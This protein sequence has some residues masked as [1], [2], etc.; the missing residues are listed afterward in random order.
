[1]EKK[2]IYVILGLVAAAILVWFI[3]TKFVLKAQQQAA[4]V[5]TPSTPTPSPLPPAPT[6]PPFTVQVGSY[7]A[8]FAG[9][10]VTIATSPPELQ[11][12][13]SY[14]VAVN[15]PNGV[16]VLIPYPVNVAQAKLQQGLLTPGSTYVVQVVPS[17][18]GAELKQ[19]SSSYAAYGTQQITLTAGVLRDIMR[20]NKS[21][22]LQLYQAVSIN[23]TP[24]IQS[25]L[26]TAS[27]NP[28]LQN[29]L[30]VLSQPGNLVAPLAISYNAAITLGIVPPQIQSYITNPS[31]VVIDFGYA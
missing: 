25:L 5:P 27:N 8:N 22:F 26:A 13:D 11:I 21:L 28:Q 15:A 7:L 23:N 4:V 9:L 20:G 2:W 24:L 12:G 29:I 10:P 16:L 31:N 1:M 6:M 17:A 30:K 18:L 3:L 14:W 19:Q